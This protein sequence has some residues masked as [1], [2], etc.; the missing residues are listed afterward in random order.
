MQDRGSG[1]EAPDSRCSGQ[2]IG[3]IGQRRLWLL[4]SHAE[5]EVSLE[6]RLQSEKSQKFRKADVY[7]C[8][9]Y[10]IRGVKTSN[11]DNLK[12]LLSLG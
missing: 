5:D 7:R 6:V 4:A 12:S 3:R 8:R 2:K 10:L 1:D 9:V 11:L